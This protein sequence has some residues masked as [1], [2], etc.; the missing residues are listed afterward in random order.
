DPVHP[1]MMPPSW[2]IDV[3][4]LSPV[5]RRLWAVA[6]ALL[7]GLSAQVSADTITVYSDN[8]PPGDLLTGIY[9]P[10]GDSGWWSGYTRN[11]GEVGIRTNFPHSGNGSVYLHTNS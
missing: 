3:L 6:A 4:T 9:E 7:V 2:R 8:G 11:G 1:A 5:F 10:F